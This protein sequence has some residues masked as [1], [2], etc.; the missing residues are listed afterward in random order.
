MNNI[1]KS[2]LTTANLGFQVED[3]GSIVE[4]SLRQYDNLSA[5]DIVRRALE[6]GVGARETLFILQAKHVVVLDPDGNPATITLSDV[7]EARDIVRQ[8]LAEEY[9]ISKQEAKAII[10]RRSD[11]ASAR[12]MHELDHGNVRVAKDLTALLKLQ[13]TVYGLD[14][15]DE[16]ATEKLKNELDAV[17]SQSK[18]ASEEVPRATTGDNPRM[19]AA[20]E[21]HRRHTTVEDQHG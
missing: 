4:L 13:A 10:L 1:I 9:A 6:N 16:S 2:G 12:L 19:Q 15:D 3:D 14:K 11:R 18:H 21:K 20:L 8:E 5:E 17:N 7:M